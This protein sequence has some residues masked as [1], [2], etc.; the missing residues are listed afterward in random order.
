MEPADALIEAIQD[1]Y[2]ARATY[3]AVLQR[4]G[5]IR[6][7]SNIVEA[8]ERHIQALL[9]LFDSY[10]IPVPA[11]PWPSRVRAPGSVADACRTGIRAEVDNALMYDRL[12]ES[13]REFPDVERVL[14]QLKKASSE[15]HLPAFRRCLSRAGRGRSA[16]RRDTG[17]G[18]DGPR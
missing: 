4:F 5:D 6:P 8:E 9:P 14:M 13:V 3:R 2:K 16:S 18:R 1:E 10:G 7:F 17:P 12:I 11:D 15:H